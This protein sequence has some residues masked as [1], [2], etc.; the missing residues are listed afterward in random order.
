VERP[1]LWSKRRCKDNSVRVGKGDSV[2]G[3]RAVLLRIGGTMLVQN[4]YCRDRSNDNWT[5][6]VSS[7]KHVK[8]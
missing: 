2:L 5:H 6:V 3:E 7:L 8:S 4:V 1:R